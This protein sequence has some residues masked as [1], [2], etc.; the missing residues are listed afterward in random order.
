[1]QFCYSMPTL[2]EKSQ[3]YISHT[4]LTFKNY[5]P[6]NHNFPICFF[7]SISYMPRLIYLNIG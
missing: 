2:N 5:Y 1:M 3:I 4:N 6:I 7:Q